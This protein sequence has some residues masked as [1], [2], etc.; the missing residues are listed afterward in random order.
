[1]TYVKEE[2]GRKLTVEVT[3]VTATTSSTK[4]ELE[5]RQDRRG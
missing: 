1:L 5:T 3:R 2:L 4:L